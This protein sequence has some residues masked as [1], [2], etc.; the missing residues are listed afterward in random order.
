MN[1]VVSAQPQ[2]RPTPRTGYSIPGQDSSDLA[3]QRLCVQV[4]EHSGSSSSYAAGYGIMS[5]RSEGF[6]A[7]G[8]L[9]PTPRQRYGVFGVA[10]ILPA[11]CAAY[12][13]CMIA[14]PNMFSL[15]RQPIHAR[16]PALY[17]IRR[18]SRRNIRRDSRRDSRRRMRPSYF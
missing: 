17:C 7:I 14:Y 3:F 11:A 5:R 4:P 9:R 6:N 15:V 13:A 18:D 8:T 16:Y 10:A 12:G 2:W 1:A